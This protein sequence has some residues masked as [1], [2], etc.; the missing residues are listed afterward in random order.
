MISTLAGTV[1]IELAE[2]ERILKKTK[3]AL[4]A[5]EYHKLEATVQTLAFLTAEIEQ[6]GTTIKNLRNLLFGPGS[7]KSRR[8][9]P[10]DGGDGAGGAAEE[11]GAAGDEEEGS[12]GAG[13]DS[14][15]AGKKRKG[16]RKGHGRNGAEKYSGAETIHVGHESLKAGDD[17]PVENCKGKVYRLAE[18]KVLIRIQGKAPLSGKVY[19]LERLR[20]N[21]CLTIFTAKAPEGV[22]EKKY[23]ESAVAMMATMRYG[24][25]LP[26]SRLE[27]LQADMGIPLAASTQWDVVNEA[28]G[29]FGPVYRELIREAAQGDVVHND[30]TTMKILELMK[31]DQEQRKRGEPPGRRGMFTSGIVSVK[32]GR[33]IALFFTGR[34]HA[35]ENLAKVLAEREE[36]LGPVIQMCDALAR[37]V[38]GEFQSIVSGCMSHARRG[39]VKVVESFP[40]ECRFVLETLAVV[41]KNDAIASR[42]KM[43]AAE[44]L[45]FHRRESLRPMAR[46]RLWAWKQLRERRVEPNS[47]L[48]QAIAYMRK[49]WRKLTRFLFVAGAPLHNNLCERVL[50]KAILHRNNS[51]F[52]KT[53]NGARVG[54]LYMSL[55][56]SC[57]LAGANP[58]D[59][60]TELQRHEAQL[61][62]NPG[63]WMPWNYRGTIERLCADRPQRG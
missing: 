54:D 17:C 50:K 53:E 52:Y 18:P 16:K 62:E 43:T 42:E 34:E 41:F 6:K 7:E 45:E 21:L 46:L 61:R 60:L 9:L 49:H 4:S 19:K 59:Y 11:K 2:L 31:Q 1:Q 47:G 39:Y 37:N 26:L 58:V 13:S 14:E 44:R 55:I 25:G 63:E 29:I 15:G 33:R 23:D 36:S 51:L 56:A 12:E 22:G 28:S 30:D 10:E 48:G 40:Q 3:S 38:S 57:Q 35:G 27:R 8:V 20:C 24:A 32:E 5:E